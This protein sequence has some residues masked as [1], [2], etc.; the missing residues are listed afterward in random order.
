LLD[1]LPNNPP[2]LPNNPAIAPN[3]PPNVPNNPPNLDP[4]MDTG[5]TMAEENMSAYLNSVGLCGGVLTGVLAVIHAK[6][7]IGFIAE[8][9][10]A[11]LYHHYSPSFLAYKI[12][13]Q[14]LFLKEKLLNYNL[15]RPD[16]K[17]LIA[18]QIYT[19][20]VAEFQT[21]DRDSQVGFALNPET[22]EVLRQ[23]PEPYQRLIIDSLDD[24]AYHYFKR[25]F[26]RDR[27]FSHLLDR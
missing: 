5:L 14:G 7:E 6:N 16:A 25:R 20:A 26:S 13:I 23:F 1:Y 27:E 15:P 4:T 17:F 8:M 3:V 12:N 10:V 18:N 19:Q 21:F 24:R 2:N 9:H 22:P 11:T